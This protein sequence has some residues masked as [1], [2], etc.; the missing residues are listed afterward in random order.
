MVVVYILWPG[1]SRV[2]TINHF[3]AYQEFREVGI[4]VVSS[5]SPITHAQRCKTQHTTYT[6]NILFLDLKYITK[7]ARKQKENLT[8]KT[9]VI[10]SSLS[11]Y[12]SIY[13]STISLFTLSYQKKKE[14][15]KKTKKRNS[16]IFFSSCYSLKQMFKC[17]NVQI[18]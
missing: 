4:I 18:K 12:L 14:E 10:L 3:T 6:H 11:I 16:K 2:G 8:K 17:L 15:E 9:P 7:E 5:L 1:H 13:L